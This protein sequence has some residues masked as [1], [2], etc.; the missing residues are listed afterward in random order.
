[1][2]RDWDCVRKILAELEAKGDANSHLSPDE[3]VGF[4]AETVSYHIKLMMEADLIKGQ[5]VNGRTLHCIA[6]S[7][8]WPGHEFLDKIRSDSIW[9]RVKSMAREQSIP[10]SFHVITALATKAIE[11]VFS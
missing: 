10:L 11:H 6:Q 3:V 4:D 2:R 1:M 5:C 7:L 9:N 8:T